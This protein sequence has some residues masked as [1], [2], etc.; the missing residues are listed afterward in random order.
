M[1]VLIGSLLLVGVKR[2]YLCRLSNAFSISFGLHDG[3]RRREK[4]M[5][6]LESGNQLRVAAQMKGEAPF[7]L[8]VRLARL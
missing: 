3:S 6:N 2:L 7:D 4:R 5:R 8:K 1:A